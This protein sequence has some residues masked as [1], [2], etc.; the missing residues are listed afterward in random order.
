MS[1]RA[2]LHFPTSW[3]HFVI[4]APLSPRARKS[5]LDDADE[6]LS[7]LTRLSRSAGGPRL[8]AER[9]PP[10]LVALPLLDLGPCP[11]ASEALLQL[12]LRRAAAAQPSFK[13]TPE[14][15]ALS[16]P[17]PEKAEDRAGERAGELLPLVLSL[18]LRDRVERLEELSSALARDL[19]RYGFDV[20]P[21]AEPRLPLAALALGA[22][23]LG[24]E[25]EEDAGALTQRRALRALLPHLPA[26]Q[27]T[28]IWINELVLL[29]RPHVYS[30]RAG[31]EVACAQTLPIERDGD[32]APAPEQSGARGAAQKEPQKEDHPHERAGERCSHPASGERAADHRSSALLA[33]LEARLEE[34][35]QPLARPSTTSPTH[36]PTHP[37]QQRPK[38]RR[39][40]SRS[41]NTTSNG[42]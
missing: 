8:S 14:G 17:A 34:R 39:R 38:R 15:W 18:T 29:R 42:D 40:P 36:H 30:P 33:A 12:A 20:S 27:R 26:P 2:P 21:L 3:T 31:Y 10:P 4:A 22:L 16:A 41:G 28:P 19:S 13:V 37:T 1:E 25:E 23:T 9:L 6:A 7:A 24:A 35:S 32:P 5:A 11:R